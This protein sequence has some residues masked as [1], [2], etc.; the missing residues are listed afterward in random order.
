MTDDERAIQDVVQTWMTASMAGDMETVL[1]LMSDDVVFLTPGKEP[2]G[3][4]EF[5]EQQAA[6][7]SMRIEGK[8]D[9]R[10]VHASASRDWGF[11]LTDL[12]VSVTPKDGVG[13][14]TRKRG[15][16][17]TL[18]RRLPNDRWVLARDAN[19]LI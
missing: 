12:D 13:E 3:K 17:L 19:L 5:V 1:S 15:Y 18:F 16:A 4:K 2:F 14:T 11:A 7:S 9:V 10:E 8:A 6:M